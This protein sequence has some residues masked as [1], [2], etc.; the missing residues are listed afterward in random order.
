MLDT[1]RE[2]VLRFHEQWEKEK[3]NLP[4]DAKVIDAIEGQLKIVPVAGAKG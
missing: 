2:T 3:T 1:A 4:L